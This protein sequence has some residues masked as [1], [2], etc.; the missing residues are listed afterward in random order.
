V[1]GETFREL[2]VWGVSFKMYSKVKTE[3]RSEGKRA[4]EREREREPSQEL[5]KVTEESKKPWASFSAFPFYA[6]YS[7]TK[8]CHKRSNNDKKNLTFNTSNTVIHLTLTL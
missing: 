2:E 6:P 7:Q 4:G 8:L 5:E 1:V 3:T